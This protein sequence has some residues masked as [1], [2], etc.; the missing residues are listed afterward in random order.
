M[1]ARGDLGLELPLEQVPRRAEGHHRAPPA[2]A[3]CPVIVATQVLESMRV[4]PR[5]TRAE[6]SD[7]AKAV[8]EGADAIMLAGETAAG[9]LSGARGARRSGAIMPRSRDGAAHA[10]ALLPAV[11]PT[12][13]RHGRALCE[14]AVTLATTGQADAIV[15]VTERGQDGA[16]ARRR[17]GRRA[18]YRGGHA[19]RRAAAHRLALCWGVHPCRRRRPRARGR[20]R[21]APAP[22]PARRPPA[23]S[24]SSSACSPQ[25]GTG[26]TP[27]SCTSEI[28]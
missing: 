19:Q 1:V 9:S 10:T 26:P 13:S 20:V 4:E 27:I 8:D 28:G 16:D 15:A 11:D 24:W 7:A 2:C 3:A 6:V 5:P 12:G 23:R 21:G 18:R 14:A 22:A 17:C 25:L